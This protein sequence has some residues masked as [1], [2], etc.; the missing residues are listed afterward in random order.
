M[1]GTTRVAYARVS[2]RINDPSHARTRVEVLVGV[3]ACF[4]FM[5]SISYIA[6]TLCFSDLAR[7]LRRPLTAARVLL[8]HLVLPHVTQYKM[9]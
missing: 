5:T 1:A 3:C 8:R 2:S 9:Q 4:I 6:D 7:S